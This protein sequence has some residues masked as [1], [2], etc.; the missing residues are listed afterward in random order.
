MTSVNF[1]LLLNLIPDITKSKVLL[2]VLQRYYSFRNV[3]ITQSTMLIF[4][5]F[6][7]CNLL[8]ES[9]EIGVIQQLVTWKTTKLPVGE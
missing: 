7:S 8:I 9:R 5:L 1:L 6:K 2:L 4:Y 3:I